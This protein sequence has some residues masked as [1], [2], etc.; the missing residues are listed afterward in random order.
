T[1]KARRTIFFGRYEASQFGAAYIETEHLLL[2]LLR[3]DKALANAFLG[4]FDKLEAM[5]HSIEQRGPKGPKIPTSVDMPL[6]HESKRVLAYAAEEAQS[7]NHKHIGTPHLL[8]GLLR[9]E[10]CFAAELLREQGLTLAMVRDQVRKS[11]PAREPAGAQSGSGVIGGLRLWIA[12]LDARQDMWIVERGSVG[13]R[14]TDFAIYVGGSPKESVNDQDLAPAAKL[15]QIHRR[16]EFVTRQMEIA[17]AQ[18]EFEK[19]RFYSD[20]ERKECENMRLLR[21]QFDLEEP[22]PRAPVLCIEVVRDD[23]FFQVQKRCEDYLAAGVAE[24]WLL[25]PNSK[26]AYTFTR[27]EGLREF[28]GEI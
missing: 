27:T 18:H 15:A 9:D 20:E 2:G 24:V 23:V 3:E 4:S 26:R 10:N 5:R 8:L 7:L 28:Q 12:E 16:I 11:E 1:E 13:N 22:P 17:I 19:A 25:N 21:A 14:T 6:S